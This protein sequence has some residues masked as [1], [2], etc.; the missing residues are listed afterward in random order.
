MLDPESMVVGEPPATVSAS[1]DLEGESWQATYTRQ[2]IRAALDA[3][4]FAPLAEEFF[5]TEQVSPRGVR[6][7]TTFV[8]GEYSQAYNYWDGVWDVGWEG[9]YR[10]RG[11]RVEIAADGAVDTLRWKVD[12][13]RVVFEPVSS[14]IKLF[15]GIPEMAYL[16]AYFAA[17]P[18]DRV[19]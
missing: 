8:D 5:A 17:A 4:G 7:R 15:K 10:I 12:G 2:Q 19:R 6:L 11:D 3:G 9:T 1:S 16:S 14:T 13:D 18:Y